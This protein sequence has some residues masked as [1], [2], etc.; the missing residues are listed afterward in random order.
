MFLHFALRLHFAP[1]VKPRLFVPPQL[2]TGLKLLLVF[3]KKSWE[4][5]KKGGGTKISY[6]RVGTRVY[7]K[8]H[9][10]CSFA[11]IEKQI[12]GKTK[13]KD[14]LKKSTIPH[15]GLKLKENK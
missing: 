12:T 1:C 4:N 8:T 5:N 10:L 11:S 9:Q 7:Q 13:T 15:K 3:D 2:T 6:Q 14:L